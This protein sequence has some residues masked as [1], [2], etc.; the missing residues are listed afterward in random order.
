MLLAGFSWPNEG[1]KWTQGGVYFGVRCYLLVH[2][3][4]PAVA[5]A[6]RHLS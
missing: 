4:L 1:M 6:L 2:G 3:A 5:S